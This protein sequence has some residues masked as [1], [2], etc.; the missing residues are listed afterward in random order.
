MRTND[1][2]PTEYRKRCRRLNAPGDA[3][4]L[5]FSCFH[6]QP[7]LSRDRS[8]RWMIET[9]AKARTIH[10]FHLWAYVLMPEHAHI[11]ICPTGSEY[12]ISAV[13]LSL[14]QPVTQRAVRFVRQHAPQFLERM[15]DLQPNGK[16]S[17]RFWQ[18]G[19]GYDRN[20]SEPRY[21][22]EMIDYI[23]AN[24]VRRGLCERAEEWYWSSASDYLVNRP[25]PLVLDRTS[26]PEDPRD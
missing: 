17:F 25:G 1:R 9:I 16:E 3:H 21:V 24:L 10:Q 18:R 12:S 8:R 14:K 2:D 13:L 4:A 20:L 19:G 11:L 23:H 26:L 15:R 22:W 7:L 5:T 6:G